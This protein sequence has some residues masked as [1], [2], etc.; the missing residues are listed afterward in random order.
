MF[1]SFHA[2]MFTNLRPLGVMIDDVAAEVFLFHSRRQLV[3]L[4][5]HARWLRDTID[6]LCP[7]YPLHQLHYAN[8]RLKSAEPHGSTYTVVTE[9]CVR[10]RRIRLN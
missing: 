1:P 6:R 3:R 8:L 7:K 4:Q 9:R 5:L 10:V 2:K